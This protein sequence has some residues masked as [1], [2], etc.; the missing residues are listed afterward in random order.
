M[1]RPSPSADRRQLSREQK[2]GSKEDQ[3]K[4][5]QTKTNLVKIIFFE[6]LQKKYFYFKIMKNVDTF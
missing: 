6:E 5:I 3:F 1:S 2:P 4:S